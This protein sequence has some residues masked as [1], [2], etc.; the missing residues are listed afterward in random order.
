MKKLYLISALFAATALQ[1]QTS[2]LTKGLSIWFDK[3]CQ[4]TG[5]GSFY[6]YSADR[7]WEERSLPIGNGSFGGNIF[8]S[9]A[10][11]RVT[12]NEK[13]LWRG[14]PNTSKGAEYYWTQ[15]TKQTFL[16]RTHTDG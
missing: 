11:E 4:L 16:Q 12:L 13:T 1:A 15:R 2:D 6:N 14:G 9:V 8:G 3:P 5:A 7:D 10:A